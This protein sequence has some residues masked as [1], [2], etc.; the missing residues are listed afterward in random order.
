MQEPFEEILKRIQADPAHDDELFG[1]RGAF[2]QQWQAWY[3]VRGLWK[4][5]HPEEPFSVA[6]L[7]V[8]FA[9]RGRTPAE[10]GRMTPGE[11]EGALR[12]EVEEHDPPKPKQYLT[13]WR[14]I[15]VAL[16]MTNNSEDREKVRNLNQLYHG[17]IVTPKQGAQPK[18]DKAKLIAWW[19]HLDA[20]FTTGGTRSGNAAA[21]VA[22]QH[23]Y[24]AGGTVTPDIS[25]EVKARRRTRSKKT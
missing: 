3:A 16:G 21:T 5:L 22:A 7:K 4:R 23:D 13:N 14:E 1:A 25:G 15:L 19:N 17:P 10:T 6:A 11:L 9:E 18:V 8:H 24:G 2:E 12:A 20:Q